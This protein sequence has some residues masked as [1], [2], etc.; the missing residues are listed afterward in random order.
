VEKCAKRIF[1]QYT[2]IST[3][4]A[5]ASTHS[6]RE[7]DT[8]LLGFAKRAYVKSMGST[9]DAWLEGFMDLLLE[10]QEAL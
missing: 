6:C 5:G 10:Q 3:S 7:S 4:V 9:V 1:P 2:P 8:L